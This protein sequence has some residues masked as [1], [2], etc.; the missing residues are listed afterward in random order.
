MD[1]VVWL[2]ACCVG[3]PPKSIAASLTLDSGYTCRPHPLCLAPLSPSSILLS[4]VYSP[5]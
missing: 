3:V 5:T 2:G 4:R 1:G